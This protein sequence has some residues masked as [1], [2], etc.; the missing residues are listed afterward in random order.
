MGCEGEA[1]SW[2]MASFLPSA[3][4]VCGGWWVG[5]DTENGD[6]GGRLGLEDGQGVSLN[7]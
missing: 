6:P 1:G 7:M 2:R 3:M 5:Q 4:G